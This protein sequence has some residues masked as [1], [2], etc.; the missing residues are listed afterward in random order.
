LPGDRLH[1]SPDRH[2]RQFNRGLA[3]RRLFFG[4]SGRSLR[5]LRTSGTCWRRG[6]GKGLFNWRQFSLDLIFCLR[7]VLSGRADRRYAG[8]T[9]SISALYSV[10]YFLTCFS[11]YGKTAVYR[12]CT[13]CIFK[14]FP[15]VHRFPLDVFQKSGFPS[16]ISQPDRISERKPR[17]NKMKRRLIKNPK[18]PPQQLE[19]ENNLFR[20]AQECGKLSHHIKQCFIDQ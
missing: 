15:R 5:Y 16:R 12:L 3:S 20:S 2:F 18:Y 4:G 8:Q 17:N 10:S 1:F 9:A 14:R 19:R 6:A 7:P 11:Y 13:A